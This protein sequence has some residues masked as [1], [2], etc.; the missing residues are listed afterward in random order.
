MAQNI[1]I[2]RIDQQGKELERSNANFASIN[3]A[4]YKIDKYKEKYPW[5]S[6][7]DE[8]GYTSFN[9]LQ[10]PNLISELENFQKE[11]VAEE[12]T[13]EIETVLRDVRKIGQFEYIKFIGD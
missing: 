1:G 7:I 10:V 3:K 8:Y 5:I 9:Y 13:G 4:L 6:G 12:L 11:D 2:I